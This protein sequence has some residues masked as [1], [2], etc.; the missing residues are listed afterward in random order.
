MAMISCNQYKRFTFFMA[1]PLNK[2]GSISPAAITVIVLLLFVVLGG[3]YMLFFK[4]S[5]YVITE[6]GK[7][8]QLTEKQIIQLTQKV[9]ELIILPEETPLVATV[10]DA[11]QLRAEQAF[12]NDVQNGDKLLIFPQAAKA[13]IYNEASHKIVN[14]GP[15]FVNNDQE[16]ATNEAGL[17]Q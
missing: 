13:I 2:S 12:Y 14:A 5:G 10:E 7:D 3:A 16:H 11:A 15:I 6:P 4:S 9:G 8:G 1:H 17:Q